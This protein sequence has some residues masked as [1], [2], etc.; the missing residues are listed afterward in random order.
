MRRNAFPLL[1]HSS[2][3]RHSRGYARAETELGTQSS[4]PEW[5]AGTLRD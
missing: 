2:E 1:A 4:C 5:I 3:V